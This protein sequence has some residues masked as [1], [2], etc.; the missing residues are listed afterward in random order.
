MLMIQGHKEQNLNHGKLYK[1]NNRPYLID[2]LKGIHNKRWK[3]NLYVKKDLRNI[4]TNHN[5]WTLFKS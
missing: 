3:W 4:S 2:K 5:V 1:T